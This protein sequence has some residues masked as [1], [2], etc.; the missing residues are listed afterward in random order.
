MNGQDSRSTRDVELLLAAMGLNS[1]PLGYTLVVI[2][3]YLNNI[4]F[5]GEVIG[6]VTAASSIGATVAL[7]PFAIAADRYGRAL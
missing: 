2:P 6:A 1:L 4:G 5:S 7:V 3:I